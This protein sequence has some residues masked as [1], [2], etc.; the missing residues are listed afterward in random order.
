MPLFHG[1]APFLN[2]LFA[3]TLSP[4]RSLQAAVL[5]MYAALFLIPS[6]A[7]WA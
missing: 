7:A 1:F 3:P 2:R 5:A 4:L 6:T